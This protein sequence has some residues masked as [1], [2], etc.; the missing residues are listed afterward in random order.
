[1]LFRSL[2]AARIPCGAVNDLA[3]VMEHPQLAHSGLVTDVSSPAGT[4]PT[5]G[6]PFLVGG[7]R[8][9]LGA[10]PALGEHT[11]EVLRELG[12]EPL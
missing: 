12:I 5:I 9:R 6:N 4:I 1:M 2:R 8:G 10:V 3:A 11:G 7:T